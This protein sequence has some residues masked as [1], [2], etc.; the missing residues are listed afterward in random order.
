LLALVPNAKEKLEFYE[1]INS[2]EFFDEQKMPT[3]TRPKAKD[4][5]SEGLAIPYKVK[6]LIAQI[7]THLGS[8]R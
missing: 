3:P 6:P 5:E 4:D 2:E 7:V 1:K 8:S